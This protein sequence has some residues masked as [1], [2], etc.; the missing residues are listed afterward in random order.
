MANVWA[1]D[2]VSLEPKVPR[3][4]ERGRWHIISQD[5]KKTHAGLELTTS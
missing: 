1:I 2:T 4:S 5:K 3:H